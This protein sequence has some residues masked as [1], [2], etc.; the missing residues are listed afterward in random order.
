M[1]NVEETTRRTKPLVSILRSGIGHA[2]GANVLNKAVGMI[3]SMIITRVMT[4]TDYGILGYALNI[5]SYLT[6]VSGLGLLSGNI[7]FGTENKGGGRAYAYYKYCLLVGLIIDIFLVSISIG[8]ISV[9]ELPLKDSKRF[10]LLYIPLLLFEYVIAIVQGILRSKN[11]IKE[12]ARY[13][14]LNSLSVAVGTCVG[15][16]WGVLGV[17]V[18]RYLAS[19]ITVAFSW[20]FLHDSTA[21]I[22]GAERLLGNEKKVLWKFSLVIG[23]CSALNLLVYSLDITLIANMIRSTEEVGLYKAGTIIPS[24]LAFVP[25]SVITAVLPNIIYHKNDMGWIRNRLNKIYVYLMGFNLILSATLILSAPL[26]MTLFAGK[27]YAKSAPVLRLLVAGYFFSGT[28]RGLSVN[29]LSAFRRVRYSLFISVSTCVA[30]IVLNHY[31][32]GKMG[33]IGAAYATLVVDILS[34]FLSFCYVFVLLKKG[35]INEFLKKDY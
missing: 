10:V 5:F 34:A 12:Y 29:L 3:S 28:F 20:L 14:N 16:F 4:T 13:L 26:V 31:L 9:L 21:Q 17:I 24:A 6:L 33:M 19:V 25:N 30:D 27:K 35:T 15:A 1:E 11:K 23:A 2:L 18:G 32:I 7:Q 22:I 8:V